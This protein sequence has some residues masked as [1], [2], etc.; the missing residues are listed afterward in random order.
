MRRRPACPPFG[1]HQAA[2]EEWIAGHGLT[3]SG[4]PG[5]SCPDEANGPRPRTEIIQPC[6][7][8]K[9]MSQADSPARAGT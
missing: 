3:A 9:D 4:Q 5:E 1:R 8:P 2:D 7:P 6:T